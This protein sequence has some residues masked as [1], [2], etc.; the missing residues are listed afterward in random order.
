MTTST[1]E[2]AR[3][4]HGNDNLRPNMQI[5][6]NHFVELYTTT[7]SFPAATQESIS[8]DLHR[9]PPAGCGEQKKKG[10]KK[11]GGTAEEPK[12]RRQYFCINNGSWDGVNNERHED[13]IRG[14]SDPREKRGGRPTRTT[15]RGNQDSILLLTN[16]WIRE[17]QDTQ[18]QK[19]SVLFT[20]AWGLSWSKNR[21]TKLNRKKNSIKFDVLS[22][23]TANSSSSCVR[24]GQIYSVS[25]Q[26]PRTGRTRR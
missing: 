25:V 8:R 12:R 21:T 15:R 9:P 7:V 23:L 3:P 1:S 5:R 11:V 10:K 22:K 13:A 14:S 20:V 17:S 4:V 16:I 24:S 2:L 18:Q 26:S 19:E 6:Q